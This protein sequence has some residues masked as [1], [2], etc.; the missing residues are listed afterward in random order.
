MVKTILKRLKKETLEA[1][2]LFHAIERIPEPIVGQEDKWINQ[3]DKI[4]EIN[5]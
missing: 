3:F 5:Q 2:A 1:A 4:N